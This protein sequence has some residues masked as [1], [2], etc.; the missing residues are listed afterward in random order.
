MYEYIF[1]ILI[2]IVWG[3]FADL[4]KKKQIKWFMFRIA[5]V[6]LFT[7]VTNLIGL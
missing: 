4:R 3:Y 7:Y 2:A 1:M 6:V 5:F